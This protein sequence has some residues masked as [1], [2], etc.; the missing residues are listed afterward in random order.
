MDLE[1]R[2]PFWFEP[3]RLRWFFS[4]AAATRRQVA[5]RRLADKRIFITGLARNCARRL[6]THI[7][8]IER[9][10]SLF[11]ESRVF[12]VEN[13][14]TDQTKAILEAWQAAS[15]GV[16]CELRDTGAASG[17]TNGL[18]VERIGRMASCRNRYLDYLRRLAPQ[19]DFVL[20]LDF[21]AVFVQWAGLVD[22]LH[23][24]GD[25]DALLA[26]GLSFRRGGFLKAWRGYACYD[27]F[28]LRP[29]DRLRSVQTPEEMS[30]V[31]RDYS[32]LRAGQPP[33]RV[34]S[35]FGGAGLYQAQ[36]LR[37]LRYE[38]RLNANPEIPVLC[39]HVGLHQDMHTTGHARI[40]LH[41]SLLVA[42]SSPWE[43][44][45]GRRR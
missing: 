44:L 19:P 28:A 30:A 21:D 22:A 20:L 2:S 35:A 11:A 23:D 14:S 8:F 1:P 26:N 7:A 33:Q 18:S 39:E 9:L 5:L 3:T 10:R 40:A 32:S 34:A 45:R 41:P 38:A 15:A 37:S 6:P 36:A 12:I 43:A 24:L 25:W 31:R 42:H 16:E 4:A 27:Y 29:A 17:A 13:D